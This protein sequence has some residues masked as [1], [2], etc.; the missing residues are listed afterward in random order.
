MSFTHSYH[1]HWP[2]L[3]FSVTA[4][5]NSFNWRFYVLI[6]LS[7]NFVRLL[8]ASSRS[9]VYHCYPLPSPAH[10]QGRYVTYLLVLI[11]FYMGFFSDTITRRSFKLCIIITLLGVYIVLQVWWPW[12]SFKVTVFFFLQKKKLQIACF[13]FV[14]SVVWTLYGC[15]TYQTDYENWFVWRW[16]VLK[17]DD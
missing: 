12:L 6:R 8:I 7:W 16:C 11:C 9:W 1:S 14:S 17:G 10:V 2:K 13:W 15:Y 4:V 5:P 3:Y